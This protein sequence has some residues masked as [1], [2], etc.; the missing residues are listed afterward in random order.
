MESLGTAAIISLLIEWAKNSKIQ[1]LAWVDHGTV[2]VTRL[3]S[4]LGAA[5]TTAGLL[6]SYQG[7]TLTVENLTISTAGLFVWEVA[8]QFGLQ[9]LAY[10]AAVR[11]TTSGAPQ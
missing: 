10:R 5:A 11:P 3:L 8:K 7:T 4:L 6:V 9:E 1:A 2:R